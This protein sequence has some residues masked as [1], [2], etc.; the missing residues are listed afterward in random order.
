MANLA[1]VVPAMTAPPPA[2][3]SMAVFGAVAGDVVL[4][5]LGVAL[6]HLARQQQ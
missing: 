5:G 6:G 1:K 2:V 4:A 3:R